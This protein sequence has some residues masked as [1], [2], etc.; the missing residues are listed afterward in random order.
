MYQPLITYLSHRL[1]LSCHKDIDLRPFQSDGDRWWRCGRNESWAGPEST[2]SSHSAILWINPHHL[3]GDS[4]RLHF[5]PMWGRNS[6][7]I[8]TNTF[9]FESSVF[10]LISVPTSILALYKSPSILT[11]LKTHIV[12][13]STKTVTF[14]V[15]NIWSMFRSWQE[16]C[17]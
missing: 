11:C 7:Y 5:V 4:G 16:N 8:H 14:E 2:A 1:L 3:R 10:Q 12:Q 15:I 13:A 6:G 9:S 17:C